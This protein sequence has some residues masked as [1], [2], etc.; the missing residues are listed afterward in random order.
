MRVF[1][2]AFLA[3]AAA[4]A[5]ATVSAAADGLAAE[6]KKA[7]PAAAKPI[8]RLC[9]HDVV[10]DK[11]GRLLPWT[12]YDNVIK[13][14]MNFIK[15]C[16]TTPTKHGGDP[17]YLV[18]S[19]LTKDGKFVANQNCQGSHAYWAVETLFRYYAYSG[20]AGAIKPVRLILDRVLMY[21][22]PADWAWPNVPRTQDNSPDGEYTDET[23]EPDKMC[24]VAVAYIKFYKLTGEEKYLN[25]ARGIAKTVAAHVGEGTAD[26]SPVPF[27]VN[28]KNG[29][30]VDDYT[31]HMISAV[32]MFDELIRLGETG[33]GV[34][35]AKRDHLWKW[36]LKY[37]LVNTLWTG[38][39]E[40]VFTGEHRNKNQQSPMETARFLLRHPEMDPEY[41]MH[42]RA[43]LD[44]VQSTFG[45]TKRLGATSIRE[46]NICP[47]EMSSHTA[48]YASVV[49][50]WFALS[51][52]PKD[53]EEARASFALT[54]YSTISRHSHDGMAINYVGL[55]YVNPWFTDS[56]F[57][58]LPHLIDG[59]AEMPEMAPA[60][61][62]HILG[63][64]SM[65]KQV[66][67][68]PGRIE[69]TP[70]DPRGSEILRI[71]FKPSKVMADGK[72]LPAAQ[73]TYGEW[74]GVPG[75]LRIQ[76]DAARN[77]V[78][79]K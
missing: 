21:H 79:E 5:M 77:I 69:Y 42:A 6:K 37:P 17:W 66:S 27:R 2:I 3:I 15:G 13:Q 29:A 1:T 74:R 72:P 64:S 59:M 70:I 61:A 51:G 38:Y 9:D 18:T 53:R 73:W 54:T 23:S 65:V 47:P 68:G 10:L 16:P 28:L 55:G 75:V 34:Y 19:K 76:R 35:V 8:T 25:A 48:R 43:L 78:I 50:K 4:L 32:L 67:Y 44:W 7:A 30:V 11:D 58:Y 71:T 12:S 20:D 31:S 60:D 14:S 39:Y 22:T 56:Y 45:K 41:K 24:I 26:K 33:D 49:A 40:D 52:D 62:D 36:I 57:D 46:Q 63:S